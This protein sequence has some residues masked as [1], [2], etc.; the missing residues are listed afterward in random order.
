M[1]A[2]FNR[3]SA[4]VLGVS[5]IASSFAS[6]ST[7]YATNQ[8]NKGQSTTHLVFCQKTGNHWTITKG[9]NPS[10]NKNR[11]Q[12][13]MWDEHA[14]GEGWNQAKAEAEF[15]DNCSPVESNTPSTPAPS[16]P[17]PSTKPDKGDKDNKGDK[18]QSTTHLIFC[19]K[20]GNHWTI[21]KGDNPSDNKN[22]TQVGTWN[23]HERGEGWNQKKAE[24]EFLKKCAPTTDTPVSS[25]IPGKGSVTPPTAK[26]TPVSGPTVTELPHTGSLALRGAL[27]AIATAAAAYGIVYLTQTKK[28]F[29]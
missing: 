23:E 20:T 5:M 2:T 10:D 26:V 21:T 28:F 22:R 6:V 7:V 17:A 29:N 1:N 16:T 3:V 4:L 14:R 8:S 27:V 18:G 9:D 25:A 24:A 12:V 11:T 19:Q 15:L 13:G